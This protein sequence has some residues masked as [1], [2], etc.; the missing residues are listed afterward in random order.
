MA[1][2]YGSCA[3]RQ[4]SQTKAGVMGQLCCFPLSRPED[5]LSKCVRQLWTE[6]CEPV[7]SAEAGIRLAVWM[8]LEMG[9]LAW[10]LALIGVWLRWEWLWSGCGRYRRSCALDVCV[11]R[12]TQIRFRCVIMAFRCRS[13]VRILIRW[14]LNLALGL[15]MHQV[16][17]WKIQL[18]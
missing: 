15:K 2:L 11:T 8:M 6:L 1:G 18:K 13:R 12:P 9:W 4:S 7:V 17:E 10:F 14:T 5:K 3:W 16:V